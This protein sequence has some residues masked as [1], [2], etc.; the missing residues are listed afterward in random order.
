MNLPL[1]A[2][3][4]SLMTL[5][6]AEVGE[7]FV[8][9]RRETDP[10]KLFSCFDGGEEAEDDRADEKIEGGGG[11]VSTSGEDIALPLLL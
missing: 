3:I 7:V 10:V 6:N 4:P 5:L 1:L 2:L 11:G 9:I 8:V